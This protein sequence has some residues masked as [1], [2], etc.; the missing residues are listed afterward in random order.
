MA[1]FDRS[2][3]SRDPSRGTRHLSRGRISPVPG[4]LRNFGAL[5]ASCGPSP[6]TWGALQKRP[7]AVIEA[8]SRDRVKRAGDCVAGGCPDKRVHGKQRRAGSPI[9]PGSPGSQSPARWAST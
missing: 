7:Y 3:S 8:I 1:S 6:Q 2:G 9:L 4:V 5:S